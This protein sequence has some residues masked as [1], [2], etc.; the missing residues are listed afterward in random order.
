MSEYSLNELGEKS[1]RINTNN[2]FIKSSSNLNT[3]R[4]TPKASPEASEFS[5]SVDSLGNHDSLVTCISSILNSLDQINLNTRETEDFNLSTSQRETLQ[6][7]VG[8]LLENLDTVSNSKEFSEI[9][10]QLNTLNLKLNINSPE[11]QE[12]IKYFNETQVIDS[13]PDLT[14]IFDHISNLNDLV[15]RNFEITK[16]H[17]VTLSKSKE[18]EK[19][20]SIALLNKETSQLEKEINING[21][22]DHFLELGSKTLDTDGN[23]VLLGIDGLKTNEETPKKF[24][25]AYLFN[26]DSGEIESTFSH[27]EFKDSKTFKGA[28]LQGNYVSINS[29]GSEYIFNKDGEFQNK[30]TA[31]GLNNRISESKIVGNELYAVAAA[32]EKEDGQIVGALFK[33]DIKSGG[34]L[35]EFKSTN[36][37]PSGT[38]G[39]NIEQDDHGKLFITESIKKNTNTGVS[40]S[41][42]IHVFNSENG[43]FEKVI[44]SEDDIQGL[45]YFG[46]NLAVNNKYLA[47][48][49]QSDNETNLVGSKIHVFDLRKD[50]Q[51]YSIRLED[52]GAK[53][54]GKIALDGDKLLVSSVTQGGRSSIYEFDLST[55]E[56]NLEKFTSILK[57]DLDTLSTVKES[58]VVNRLKVDNLEV[59]AEEKTAVRKENLEKFTEY[60]TRD[61]G[62]DKTEE[63]SSLR[64]ENL[65]KFTEYQTRDTGA[66]K[67]EEKSSRREENLEKFTEYQTRDTEINQS[68]SIRE[69][70]KE[71]VIKYVKH[72]EQS[73]GNDSNNLD[74][75]GV[76]TNLLGSK[77]LDLLP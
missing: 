24:N 74:L 59:K 48:A 31:P 64:K 43:E 16:N 1:I 30:F 18:D 60:Q 32:S 49:S 6:K 19:D 58:V 65:E 72:L 47:V 22:P 7:N 21:L 34:L 8:S 40:N 12:F 11:E 26:T 29:D 2:N 46:S 67:T 77:T 41:G 5:D 35:G 52:F 54:D 75:F 13:K 44:E 69:V 38:F 28:E 76:Q 17:I 27:P 9:K 51:A 4:I 10:E 23:H 50:Q 55:R 36:A 66:D 70:N 56:K 57:E 20:Q 33:F 39:S 68:E 62:V 63:K 73:L 25:A 15:T 53:L 45:G 37:D 42:R 3:E 14:G 61:T 71:K